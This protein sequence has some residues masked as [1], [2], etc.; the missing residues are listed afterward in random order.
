M[1][2]ILL[3]SQALVNWA[4]ERETSSETFSMVAEEV[5]TKFSVCMY[6][7]FHSFYVF[8]VIVQDAANLCGEEGM[9]MLLRITDLVNETI[10]AEAVY[11]APRLTT[12]D[13]LKAI[14]KGK[15]DGGKSGR[16]WVLDPI[17]GTKG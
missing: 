17:D 15:S 2:G 7:E 9:D 10:A 13:V 4:L 11:N 1:S 6:S 14:D 3:G 5:N 8:I 12:E 16:H